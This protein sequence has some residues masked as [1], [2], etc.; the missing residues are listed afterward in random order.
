MLAFF[1]RVS[2]TKL[3]TGIMA[4]VLIAILAGFAI[5]DISNFGSGNIGFGMGSSTLV[6]VG[7]QEITEK[8]MSDAM[9]RRLADVRQQNANADYATI[10][11]DFD[12]ILGALIDQRTLLAFADKHGF[13]VSKRLIDAEIT[14]IPQTRG[15]N[16]QFSEQAY[17]GFLARERMTDA[18]VRQ[19]IAGSLLQRMLLT[20]VTAN[21]RV[22]VG[23]AQPYASMLLEAREGEVAT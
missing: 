3:G 5:A 21:A 17:Q 19:I 22:S 2:K 13:H 10:V 11:R 7:D 18:Q 15:L 9:Q 12:V 14:Q 16:G 1:R 4:G 8:E 6:R 23:M 20:S